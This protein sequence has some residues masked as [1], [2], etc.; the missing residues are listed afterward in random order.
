M[1]HE[2]ENQSRTS[3]SAAAG[4]KQRDAGA[5][6]QPFTS[7]SFLLYYHYKHVIPSMLQLVS[8]QCV[9]RSGWRQLPERRLRRTGRLDPVTLLTGIRSEVEL[10]MQFPG[11]QVLNELLQLPRDSGR[12]GGRTLA[13]IHITRHRTHVKSLKLGKRYMCLKL[14][15]AMRGRSCCDFPK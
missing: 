1:T 12:R 6:S 14:S 9:P 3:A 2:P 7:S 11:M 4:K 10:A 13:D 5:S 8:Q 15:I